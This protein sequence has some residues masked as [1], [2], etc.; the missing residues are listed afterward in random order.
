[1]GEELDSELVSF[2]RM[3]VAEQVAESFHSYVNRTVKA[4]PGSK[5]SWWASSLRLDKNLE[6]GEVSWDAL[7]M[8]A[9]KMT[10]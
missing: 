7:V 3:P 1:M 8:P 6:F 5:L 9:T 2:E 4:A 10:A